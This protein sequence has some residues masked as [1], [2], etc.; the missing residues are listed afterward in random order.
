METSTGRS[1]PCFIVPVLSELVAR[2]SHD[3]LVAVLV[4]GSVARGDQDSQSD[5]DVLVV[6]DDGEARR[7][8]FQAL[9]ADP[10]LALSP[11][12]LTAKSL[13]CEVADRPSFIAHLL[14]EGVA[15]YETASWITIRKSLS[16]SALDVD[17]LGREV[18]SRVR[19]LEPLSTPER[20]RN[21]PVTA[22]SHLYG[23]ARSLIIARLL[24]VGIHEYSWQRAFDRY[25]EVRP[26]LRDDLEALKGLRPYYEYARARIGANAPDRVVGID[27][28]RQLVHSVQQLAK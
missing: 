3:H 23:I 11:L 5:L 22:L 13:K 28:V 2:V 19:H 24:Q 6:V 21:S 1:T 15:F 18:R 8:L 25:A 20:F 4:F 7:E 12:V 17:A 10:S 26:E 14:D 16:K 27:E 9:A